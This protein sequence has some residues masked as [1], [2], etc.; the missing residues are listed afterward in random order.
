MSETT[1]DARLIEA[2]VTEGNARRSGRHP[3]VE[4]YRDLR[5]FANDLVVRLDSLQAYIDEFD[6]DAL[7]VERESLRDQRD[8]FRRIAHELESQRDKAQARMEPLEEGWHEPA[9]R[10]PIDLA[11]VEAIQAALIGEGWECRDDYPYPLGLSRNWI[12]RGVGESC[13]HFLLAALPPEDAAKVEW[14][15]DVA[16]A[17]EARVEALTQALP[18]LLRDTY[19]LSCTPEEWAAIERA[20]A[21]LAAAPLPKENE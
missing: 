15:L 9:E 1:F 14:L 19:H 20:R 12:A 11:V 8:E 10:D 7:V 2:A 13:E 21:A 18:I 5:L 17:A 16:R 3:D 6:H 4:R